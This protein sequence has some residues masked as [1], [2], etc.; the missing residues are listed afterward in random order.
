MQGPSLPTQL[1][2][3]TLA[4]AG[5]TSQNQKAAPIEWRGLRV[6]H[7][8]KPY[9]SR[10][11]YCNQ[12]LMNISRSSNRPF[13]GKAAE[14]LARELYGVI[15]SDEVVPGVLPASP[16]P[17]HGPEQTAQLALH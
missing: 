3:M 11:I 16:C 4:P 1:P 17:S 7:Y 8:P 6:V 13:R 10:G 15:P 5:G 2:E 12:Y 9:L 14:Q